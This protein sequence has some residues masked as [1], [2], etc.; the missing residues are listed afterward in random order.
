LNPAVIEVYLEKLL[1]METTF[2]Y[3]LGGLVLVA[4]V[5]IGLTKKRAGKVEEE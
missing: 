1:H 4:V 2:L 5:L 3:I